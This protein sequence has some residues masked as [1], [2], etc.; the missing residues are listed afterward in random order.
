MNSVSTAGVGG[1]H[2]V[3][4]TVVV[5]DVRIGAVAHHRELLGVVLLVDGAADFVSTGLGQV[6]L[7]QI[8]LIPVDAEVEGGPRSKWRFRGTLGEVAVVELCA[9]VDL[10]EQ[11]IPWWSCWPA[12]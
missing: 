11:V 7:V 3:V 10:R 1:A 6:D 5:H 8:V 2:G 9:A 12:R 4:L